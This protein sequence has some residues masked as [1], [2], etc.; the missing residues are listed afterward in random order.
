MARIAI[1]GTGIAGLGCAHFLHRDHDLTLFE[2]NGYVGGHTNTVH[3]TEPVTGRALP[4]GCSPG[5]DCPRL[6]PSGIILMSDATISYAF[7]LLPSLSAHSR[8]WILPST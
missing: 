6:D 2:Q 3:V 4:A 5:D 7:R 8:D 1:I